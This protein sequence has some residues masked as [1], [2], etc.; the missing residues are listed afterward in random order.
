M[1]ARRWKA[2]FGALAVTAALGLVVACGDDDDS[3]GASTAEAPASD[4]K[5][6]LVSDVGS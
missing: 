2:L 6:G 3:A 4:I 1:R 5:A